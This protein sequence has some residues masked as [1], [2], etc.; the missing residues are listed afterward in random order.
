[1]TVAELV[2]TLGLDPLHLHAADAQEVTTA[3]CGDLLS[4]VMAH[5]QPGAVWFT[6][7]AHVNVI[8]VGEL[9]DVACIVLVNGVSPDP[10]TTARAEAQGVNLCGSERTSAALCMLLAGS[11]PEGQAG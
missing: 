8:A 5:C 4:D 7:Q 10:Q 2:S 9:R 3:Y 6:V 11:L 1:M